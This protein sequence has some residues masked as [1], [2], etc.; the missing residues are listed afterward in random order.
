MSAVADRLVV[1]VSRRSFLIAL[2]TGWSCRQSVARPTAAADRAT[3]IEWH[4]RFLTNQQRNFHKVRPLEASPALADVARSHSRDML[5]RDYFNHRSPEG[6]SPRDRVAR[7]GLTYAVVAE[8]IYSTENGS[9]DAARLASI[10]V[11]A[12]MKNAGHRRNILEPSLRVLG[13]G[14]ALSDTHVLATQL[15]AG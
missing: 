1:A 7:S 11:E 2:A 15:F 9:T 10:M 5:E 12:W 3:E 14:V 8:N 6:L 4:I 13:V